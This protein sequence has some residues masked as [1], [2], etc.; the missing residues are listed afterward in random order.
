MGCNGAIVDARRPTHPSILRWRMQEGIDFYSLPYIAGRHT[1]F[2][3]SNGNIQWATHTHTTFCVAKHFFH[4]FSHRTFNSLGLFFLFFFSS[5]HE[6]DLLQKRV[7]RVFFFLF[8]CYI[9]TKW[10]FLGKIILTKNTYTRIQKV[11]LEFG[12]SKWKEFNINCEQMNMIDSIITDVGHPPV[13]FN[14]R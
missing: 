3:W 6:I 5:C 8:V 9:Y 4:R 14:N 13:F 2:D 7:K 1:M 12:C 10:D 11:W